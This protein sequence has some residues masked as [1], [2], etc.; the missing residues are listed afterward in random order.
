[1]S[2]L[3]RNTILSDI[4]QLIEIEK[5]ANQIFAKTTDLM[6]LKDSKT[7]SYETHLYFI[8]NYYSIVAIGQTNSPIGFLYARI[9]ENDLYILEID[10]MEAFQKKGI[11]RMLM[12]HVIQY[13][14]CAGIPRVTLT[15]FT[16][17]E[18]NKPFY[19]SI[20]FNILTANLPKYI[21][22]KLKREEQNGFSKETRCAMY[23]DL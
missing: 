18:W 14:R 7:I 5:S 6:W 19:E 20:G 12:S 1:M 10:V 4:E 8:N 17:V 23:L 2:Y 16:H 21:C 11:G 22:E 15:T 3:I 13:A 9:Y